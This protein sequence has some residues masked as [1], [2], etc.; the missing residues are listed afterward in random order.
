VHFLEIPRSIEFQIVSR[1]LRLIDAYRRGIDG[2]AQPRRCCKLPTSYC[3]ARPKSSNSL[4]FT[5][6]DRSVYRVTICE[7]REKLG[8]KVHA[9]CLM[10]NHVHLIVNPGRDPANL[11][12]LMKRLAGRHSRRLNRCEHRRG[13]SW[14]GRFKCSPIESNTYLLSCAC[15]ID[16]NSVRAGMVERPEE[17]A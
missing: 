17:Y 10:T 7:F 11:G 14:E 4:F 5:E 6:S 15:Y 16:L 8:V 2:E 12:S 3:P 1:S 9:H 13:S